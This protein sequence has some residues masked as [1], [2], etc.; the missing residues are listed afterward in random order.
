MLFR[1]GVLSPTG[2]A[3]PGTE[4]QQAGPEP[5]RATV[6]T[7]TA[8]SIDAFAEASAAP[9]LRQAQPLPAVERSDVVPQAA[10]PSLPR[11]P[12]SGRLDDSQ[13]EPAPLF[14]SQTLEPRVS[15]AAPWQ[16]TGMP[17][18]SDE[19]TPAFAAAHLRDGSSRRAAASPQVEPPLLMPP[20]G[21]QAKPATPVSAPRDG[22]RPTGQGGQSLD[23][24]TEVHIHIGRIEVTA[25][26]EAPAPRTQPRKRPAPTSLEA[27]LAG[28]SR[29]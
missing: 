5:A 19:R 1:S 6:V 23:D 18:E 27:Y 9:S 10:E 29:M 20:L 8:A 7:S 15:A 25:V 3:Q 26:Q 22:G 4:M 13:G 21:A 24:S 11:L 28:R 14:R 16:A 2:A 17:V 12:V